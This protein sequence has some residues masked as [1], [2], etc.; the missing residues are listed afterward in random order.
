MT[1]TKEQTAMSIVRDRN[2]SLEKR[3]S[4][5]RQLMLANKD[6]LA[7]ALGNVLTP[8][9]AIGLCCNSIAKNPALLDC[10]PA[11]I[12]SSIAEAGSYGWVIDGVMGHAYLV[13]F[14]NVA[15]LI[16]GYKGLRDLVQRSGKCRLTLESVHEGDTYEYRG[17]FEMPRHE[18]STE[19]ARRF[20]P[21]THAY[22]IARFGKDDVQCYSW[23]VAECIA[24]R[25]QFSNSWKRAKNKKESPWH[26]EHPSFR[27]MCMKTVLRDA[28]SRGELPM[29]VEDRSMA[30][31]GEVVEKWAVE[32]GEQ[33]GHEPSLT[34]EHR[35]AEAEEAPDPDTLAGRI[36]ACQTV[37]ELR[38]FVTAEG[39]RI[40]AAEDAT[41]DDM[42]ELD[43]LAVAREKELAG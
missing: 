1:E 43:A 3:V 41:P 36:A 8:E 39:K 4:G 27:V 14:K 38:A 6:K 32:A 11:S 28:A 20:R 13:P 33:P 34:L 22:L 7:T 12:F 25:D 17:R 10:S 16:P 19:G 15:V 29:S 5:M 21:V 18:P 35:P 30:L 9:R 23:S 31:R 2:K 24:H 37:E 26:P 42:T 40:M